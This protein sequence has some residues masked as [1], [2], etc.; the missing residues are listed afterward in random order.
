MEVSSLDSAKDSYFDGMGCLGVTGRHREVN[1][2]LRRDE[3]GA[4]AQYNI[5]G[6][7]LGDVPEDVG[8]EGGVDGVYDD[9]L[10]GVFGEMDGA[11]EGEFRQTV[12]DG[13]S[14]FLKITT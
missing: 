6:Y 3:P 5:I 1:L 10:A 2:I 8:L 11:V 4:A 9:V 13:D 12:A 7:A 14:G